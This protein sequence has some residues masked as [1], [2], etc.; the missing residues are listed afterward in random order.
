MDHGSTMELQ[1]IKKIITDRL[2][3]AAGYVRCSFPPILRG[4]EA[5]SAVITQP[6]YLIVM[7]LGHEGTLR[8]ILT[9]ETDPLPGLITTGKERAACRIN[10]AMYVTVRSCSVSNS[11]TFSL[12][13]DSTILLED[14]H[15]VFE[16]DAGPICYTIPLAYIV[17]YGNNITPF[18][19]YRY[20]DGLIQY[21]INLWTES[22]LPAMMQSDFFV[23]SPESQRTFN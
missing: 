23:S 1:K 4:A 22:T 21:S 8:N 16:T 19:A 18:N 9:D 14:H 13:T 15:Q 2:I 6:D 5:V 7:F 12:G 20:L 3:R 10:D 11:F 17:S